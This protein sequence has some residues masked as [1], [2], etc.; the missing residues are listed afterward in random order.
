MFDL[1]KI[2]R[3]II[4]EMIRWGV[5]DFPTYTA[6]GLGN[7]K[8]MSDD[9]VI[10]MINIFIDDNIITPDTK[11]HYGMYYAHEDL[12]ARFKNHYTTKL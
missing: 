5:I 6:L 8:E 10:K 4:S 12:I 3:E 11:E 7:F 1:A 9:E 2:G